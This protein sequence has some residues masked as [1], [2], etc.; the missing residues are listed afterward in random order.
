M[1][2]IKKEFGKIESVR[3][4]IGGYQDCMIG[5]EL[6]LTGEGWGV[7]PME[8]MAWDPNKV[9]CTKSMEW[10]EEDRDDQLAKIMRRVSDLLFA[11]KV[12]GI[13]QLV[14]KPV[15]VTFEG[16]EIKSW[17]ILTEVL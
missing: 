17:R 11:A 5:L 16:N 14:G 7:S 15:E 2:I 13:D 3:F 1:M 6:T 12:K 9:E 10:A 8:P 4:G